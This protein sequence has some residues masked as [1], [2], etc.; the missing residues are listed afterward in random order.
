[1]GA[2]ITGSV[3]TKTNYVVVDEDAGS[4]AKVAQELGI[5]ILNEEQFLAL[6]NK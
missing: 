4:R 2:K 5:N 1:M 3:T 6:M